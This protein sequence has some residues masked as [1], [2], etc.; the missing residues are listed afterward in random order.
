MLLRWQVRSAFK[1]VIPFLDYVSQ[2]ALQPGATIQQLQGCEQRL[3]VTL[4]W[5]IWEMY[6][7]RN[8]QYRQLNIDFAYGGRLLS[9][10]ELS[11]E[12]SIAFSGVDDCIGRNE[13][14]G[15]PIHTASHQQSPD[16]TNY[17]R[18][19]SSQAV[20]FGASEQHSS[21]PWLLPFTD[22]FSKKRQFAV[23]SCGRVHLIIGLT[24]SYKT[25]SCSAFLQSLLR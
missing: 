20:T 4:P 23:D 9:L 8:G 11:L 24:S 7:F 13:T 12:H 3:G 19:N 1:Q 2:A 10:E 16:C 6:R 18:Q 21:S 22:M 14:F 17:N 25:S 5:Q 15:Q